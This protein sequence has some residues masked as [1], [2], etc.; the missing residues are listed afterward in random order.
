MLRELQE[1]R[2]KQFNKL[3]GKYKYRKKFSKEIENIKGEPNRNLELKRMVME[4]KNSVD[5]FNS[6]PDGQWQEP[7]KLSTQR[8]QKKKEWKIPGEDLHD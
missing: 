8:E 5:S 3:G 6:R 1:N 4:L 2:E 7:L